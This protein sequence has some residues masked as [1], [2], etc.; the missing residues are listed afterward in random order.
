MS[1]ICM[2]CGAAFKS[3]PSQR[4]KYC[5]L[6]CSHHANDYKLASYALTGGLAKKPRKHPALK[7]T[8]GPCPV[9]GAVVTKR[10]NKTC[11]A[12]CGYAL[13]RSH[14]STTEVP[15]HTCIQCHA[16]FHSYN[17]SRL[18]C[19]YHCFVAS[20]GPFRAGL[21]ATEAKMRYG[22]KKDA[23]HAAIIGALRDCGVPVYDLSDAGRGIP[24]CIVWVAEQWRLV[25]I[26]NPKTGY[27]RRGLN[28]VQR[29]WLDQWTGGPIIILRSVEDALMLAQH[30]FAGLEVQYPAGVT[31]KK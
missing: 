12:I 22:A 28:R 4:R 13:H 3:Q 10:K 7:K 18:Y 16:G 26:K 20:G 8:Y 11:G 17:H 9:C 21:R 2:K 19:S 24:D 15:N 25:E 30:K 29:K 27:G 1:T 23:N 14:P 5:S 6:A 31:T